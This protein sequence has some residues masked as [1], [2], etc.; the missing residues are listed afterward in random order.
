MIY[1]DAI[2][3]KGSDGMYSVRSD[4]HFGNFWFGGFGGSVAEAKDDF[5][6]SVKE[7][8]VETGQYAPAEDGED[9]KGRVQEQSCVDAITNKPEEGKC[10]YRVEDEVKISFKYDMPSFFGE[11]DFINASKFAQY[12]GINESKMRQY[13]SGSAYPSERTARKI[14]AAIRRIGEAFCEVKV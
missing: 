3:E 8:I 4:E 5:I 14:L 2:I 11:F 6:E 9:E 13:K 7:A 12:V 1:I 10:P